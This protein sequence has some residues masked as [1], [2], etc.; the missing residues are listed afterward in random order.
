M[1]SCSYPP[2]F[3]MEDKNKD[4]R[5]ALEAA[6]IKLQKYRREHSGEYVGGMQYTDLMEMIDKALEPNAN[7]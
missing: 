3:M 7:T 2:H 5:A 4:L 1:M 6:Q